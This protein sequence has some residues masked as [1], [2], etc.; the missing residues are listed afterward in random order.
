[1]HAVSIKGINGDLNL[2]EGKI[3]KILGNLDEKI[4]AI[5]VKNSE[6]P[7]IDKNFFYLTDLKKGLFEGCIAVLFSDGGVELIVSQLESESAYVSN[8]N[9]NVYKD[10]KEYK[11]ILSETLGNSSKIGLN[12]SNI[13][14]KDFINL[15]DFFPNKEFVNVSNA[16]MKSRSVKDTD[17]IKLISKAVEIADSVM[18]RIP[19][20]TKEGMKEFE[21]AA[22][23]NYLMQKCGA[24]GP[25]FDTI[26]SFGANSSQPHYSHGDKTL[27][28]G[29]FILCDFGSCF[30]KYNSDIT[31]TFV[32][33]ETDD[34]QKKMHEVVSGAQ[35]IAFE[36]I[37]PGI[38]G[39]EVHSEVEEYINKTEFAGRFIHGTGHSLGLNVHDGY[40]GLSPNS[41]IELVEN[42]VLTVEPGVYIPGF[43]GVRIEDDIL[44]TSDGCKILSKSNRDLIH[45]Y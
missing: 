43:G 13:A 3:N 24:D 39:K 41:E 36:K 31:R 26:S 15:K 18:G 32:F 30:E 14:H 21:L 9:V 33:K 22:E 1:M 45:I 10:N 25:A 44:V 20:I 42:M 6:E 35:K 19:E 11:K 8:L 27:K 16:L 29:E 34:K 37:K 28:N 40:V 7:F 4:D 38:T 23:I 2:G 12:F 5:I 17:E